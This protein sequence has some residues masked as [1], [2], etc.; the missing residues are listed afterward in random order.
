M[1]KSLV[2]V[3]G[4]VLFLFLFLV[5]K[6]AEGKSFFIAASAKCEDDANCPQI[7]GLYPFIY[8]CIDNRCKLTKVQPYIE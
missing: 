1:V 8:K 4:I 6:E 3:Y 2:F 5:G 7:F